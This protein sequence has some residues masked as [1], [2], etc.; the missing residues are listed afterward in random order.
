MSV[1]SQASLVDHIEAHHKISLKNLSSLATGFGI[2]GVKAHLADGRAVAVKSQLAAA[3]DEF[4]LEAEM[5]ET[6]GKTGW[7]VPEIIAADQHCLIMSWLDNDGS[8]LSVAGEFQVGAELARLHALP[9]KAFG[10]EK[11]TPI[12]RLP[13]NNG[14]TSSWVEFFKTNRLL[15]MAGRAFEQGRLPARLWERLQVFVDQL[16][17]I[18]DEPDAPSLLHGDIWG[19][20]VLVSNGQLSGF[21]DPAIYYGHREIELAFTQMFHTFGSEFFKGYQSVTPLDA[22]FF[23]H[24]LE[25][26]N[27]YPTLVH[28][29]LFGGSYLP[30]I[31]RVLQKFG[32]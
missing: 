13:Q 6:L 27:L 20:N 30:P 10:F 9:C 22:D 26:Y 12:G 5:L 24:R 21:I 18:I 17:D 19:G 31:E 28:V 8:S 23:H 4:L 29:V 32:V 2:E 7:P 25:V 15:S 16:D 3:S 1:S 14:L 11:T